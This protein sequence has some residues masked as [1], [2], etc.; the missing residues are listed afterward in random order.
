M[1]PTIQASITTNNQLRLTWV[2]DVGGLYQVQWA[3]KLHQ[4]I[5]SNLD[6]V[7]EAT[8]AFVFVEDSIDPEG[9]RFYRAQVLP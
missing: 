2:A 6:S 8:N 5:W 3:S 7:I 9:M 1:R 4:S